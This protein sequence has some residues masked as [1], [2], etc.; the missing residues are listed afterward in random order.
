MTDSEI[1]A[2]PFAERVQTY[3]AGLCRLHVLPTSI[4]HVVSFRGSI[5]T[6]PDFSVTDPMVQNLMVELLDKGTNKRDRFALADLTDNRGAQVGFRSGSNRI[7]FAGRVLVDDLGDL[8]ELLAEM[9]REPLFDE[10]EI[11]KARKV[12]ISAIQRSMDSTGMQAGSELSRRIF[13][14]EHPNYD[15]PPEQQ[16]EILKSIESADIWRFYDSRVGPQELTMAAAGDLADVD[17]VGRI[18]N[19]FDGW[20]ARELTG[21]FEAEGIHGNPGRVE[22]P[23]KDKQNVDVRIGHALGVR[24]NHPDFIPLQMGVHILGGNF[25]SRLMTVVRDELGLTY[26]IN[27]GL[28]GIT[29]EYDG[30]FRTAVTLSRDNVERGIEATMS[31]IDKIVGEGVSVSEVADA[32][33]TLSGSFKV[34]LS[35][36]DGMARLMHAFSILG[37]GMQYVDDYP[38]LIEATSKEDIEIALGDH[39]HPASLQTVLA[40]E[41]SSPNG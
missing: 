12:L 28:A 9:L 24:R 11:R 37:F 14:A 5:R 4:D 10:E 23:M 35:T 21:S 16:I 29:N 3:N 41:V 19:A 13:P 32:R 31:E 20:D 17:I 38:H 39:I 33:S 36:T 2:V 27:A 1:M 6:S 26:G 34:S 7:H 8:I 40:G 18:K 15:L 30:Y 25:S 22:V